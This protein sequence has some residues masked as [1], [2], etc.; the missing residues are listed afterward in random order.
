MFFFLQDIS[1]YCCI[2]LSGPH[3]AVSTVVAPFFDP[4]TGVVKVSSYLH[5]HVATVHSFKMAINMTL[6][7]ASD[8][9]NKRFVG[10]QLS[11]MNM[12]FPYCNGSLPMGCLRVCVG[13]LKGIGHRSSLIMG[14][15]RN[16]LGVFFIES[17]S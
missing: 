8:K 7:S 10:D 9:C 11:C 12:N 17:T 1:Y 6:S 3:Q 16:R 15:V 14:L 13:M 2:E 5:I 4:K